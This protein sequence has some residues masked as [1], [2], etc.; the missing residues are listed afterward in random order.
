MNR[1]SLILL[2]LVGAV[3]VAII[4]VV[5]QASSNEADWALY[6]Q[7]R[8]GE[9][10]QTVRGRFEAAGDDLSTLAD[11]RTLGYGSEF[12]E[13]LE[14]AAVRMFVVP[15]RADAFI[16]AFSQDGRLVYKNFRKP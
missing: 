2:L 5:R 11:A 16:F 4:Y 3:A 9:S 1:D 7:T 12:K 14:A 13:S 10:Y 8:I 6:E 15:S